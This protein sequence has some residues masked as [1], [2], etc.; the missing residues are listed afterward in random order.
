MDE[1]GTRLPGGMRGVPGF[2]GIV[3]E[4]GKNLPSHI[5]SRPAPP[6][7]GGGF[8]RSAH[9]ASRWIRS[10]DPIERSDLQKIIIG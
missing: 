2:L 6:E 8:N 9:S 5:Q 3:Q 4:L 7:G 1:A 10:K